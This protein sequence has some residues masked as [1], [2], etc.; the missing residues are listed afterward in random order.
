MQLFICMILI[1]DHMK[2]NINKYISILFFA[3]LGSLFYAFNANVSFRNDDLLYSLMFLKEYI[4]D[5]PQP[6]DLHSPITTLG[7]IFISQYNHY[8]SMNGRSPVQ[9]LV[10]LFCGI[11]GKD[12]FNVCTS[13]VYIFFIVGVTK[14]IYRKPYQYFHYIGAACMLWF[15]FPVQ[16]FFS[17]GISFSINY[18][19]SLTACV[20]FLLLYREVKDHKNL[21][22]AWYPITL[23][24]SFLAGWSHEGFSISISGALFFY[25]LLHHKEFKG[26]E[27]GIVIAFWLGTSMIVF[28]PG[29][30]SRL[31]S[32]DGGQEG[33]LEFIYSR[34]GILFMMKR[35]GLL[36]IGTFF[37]MIIR[38]L[39]LKEFIKSNQLF[40]LIICNAVLFILAIGF[41][42]ERSLLGIE[43][44]AL[45]LFMRMLNLLRFAQWKY[46]KY[47]TLLLCCLFIYDAMG[48]VHA[49]TVTDKEYR[50]I[51][52]NYLNDKN[53]IAYREDLPISP[54][55]GKYVNRLYPESWE[56]QAISFYYGKVMHLFPASYKE[57]FSHIDSY[58]L[59][60]YKVNNGAGLYEIP[61]T[62]IYIAQADSCTN[63]SEYIYKF[64]YTPVPAEKKYSL[65]QMWQRKV[66]D[67]RYD[68]YEV[69]VTPI[70]LEGRKVIIID[71]SALRDRKLDSVT[72]QVNVM[73]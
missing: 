11:F 51:V 44:F 10:Q 66:Y 38:Q 56:V 73:K 15:L 60:P 63:D 70:T 67:N 71:N 31:N 37:F 53:G 9:F 47:A 35:L 21:L 6:V 3:I 34:I 17:S 13:L 42:N 65:G 41:V 30:L 16:V 14:L 46:W 58:L 54:H 36:L 62:G 29:S 64:N 27:M 69:K 22:K 48:A 24:I 8:F 4:C 45:L 72:M 18:L 43:F 52:R 28:S 33:V 26:Q 49:L 19:W 68:E 5:S 61:E 1:K 2:E 25:Y 39:D 12:A 32:T 20:W 55:Y 57:Y 50:S 7:D 23:F 59:P 40:I